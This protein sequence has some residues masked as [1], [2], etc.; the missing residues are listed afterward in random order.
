MK[1]ERRYSKVVGC[2]VYD[3]DCLFVIGG[4]PSEA[5]EELC[6]LVGVSDSVR[7][8]G[9][10][11]LA[12]ASSARARFLCPP[13]SRSFAIWLPEIPETP[14]LIGSVAHECL[15]AVAHLMAV[16]G[17]EWTTHGKENDTWV[18]DEPF[19]Y[20]LGFYVR[21]F[22]LFAEGVREIVA[23]KERRRY[24]STS[25]KFVSRKN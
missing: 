14:T 11:S 5:V 10:E 22:M 8:R 1:R 23:K 7:A 6:D 13:G 12:G 18:N 24:V 3:T 2:D 19:C 16:S 4:T 17:V 25:E 15:H 21:E 20:L 9:L